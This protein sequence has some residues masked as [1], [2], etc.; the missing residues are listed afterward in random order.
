MV[1]LKQDILK[2]VFGIKLRGF[3]LDKGLSLKDLSLQAGLSP[4]YLN[5]IEKGKKYPKN[6]KI[7]LLAR[8]LDEKTEDLT[9]LE[10]KRDL[11]VVQNLLDDKFLTSVP[12][13][14]FGIPSST[15]F[16]LLAERPQKLQ[17][18][19]RT[20]IEIARTHNIN[21]NDF[22]GALLR[23][24]INMHEN[25][26]PVLVEASNEVARKYNINWNQPP[27]ELKNQLTS[28]LK[29]LGVHVDETIFEEISADLGEL[30]YFI[31][32]NKKFFIS[33]KLSDKEKNY[34]LAR[35][36][37]YQ[38]LKL[39]ER[40]AT[41]LTNK[42]E[43]FTHLLN[44]FSASYFAANLIIPEKEIVTDL[45][46]FFSQAKWDADTLNTLIN[47][48]S[49]PNEIFFHRMLQVLPKH[50][51]IKQ[52]FFLHNI[53]DRTTNKN[54]I[55]HELHL[56]KPHVPHRMVGNLEHS[57]SL[58]LVHRLA[59][60]HLA[61]EHAEVGIQL[62]NLLDVSGKE[63]QYLVIGASLQ[64]ELSPNTIESFCIGIDV[65]EQVKS[66]IAWS[67]STDVPIFAIG[68][69]CERCLNVCS[70]RR[71]P[72]QEKYDQ[73]KYERIFKTLDEL[74]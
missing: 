57:C 12:F 1:L 44:Y 70:E 73:D 72:F 14:L 8:A 36:I 10:L 71:V 74:N 21:I 60:K 23:S 47:K 42:F 22:L 43:T 19:T 65:T 69:T 28:C 2:L 26:F 46:H 37:G 27:A 45:K 64:R 29:N 34:I 7:A 6:E 56:A 53:Y 35:E 52:L 62:S 32:K 4:S 24:Y 17:S 16:E 48:Y 41:S 51:G 58:W 31:T 61:S 40:N 39:K 54:E 13:D 25:Y 49:G 3:R 30:T 63:N 55:L 5:E 59:K 18:F 33:S 38:H 67:N 50:F 15:I 66:T 20:I 68:E 11:E 9:S